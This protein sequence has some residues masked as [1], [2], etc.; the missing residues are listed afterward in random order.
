VGAIPITAVIAG[1]AVAVAL[2]L[3]SETYQIRA[4]ATASRTGALP[5]VKGT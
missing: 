4:V 3:T 2:L 5:G 1:A